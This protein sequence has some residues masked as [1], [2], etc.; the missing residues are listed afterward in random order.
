MRII[1]FVLAGALAVCFVDPGSAATRG[2][3]GSSANPDRG[4]YP[5][6]YSCG[7]VSCYRSGS[8]KIQK[9]RHNH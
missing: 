3:A 6:S 5:S 4:P 1:A 8:Q 7:G 2:S 9:H